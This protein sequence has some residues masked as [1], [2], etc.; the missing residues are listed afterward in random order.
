MTRLVLR[1]LAL[2]LLPAAPLLATVTSTPAGT[3]ADGKKI[4]WYTLT[5]KQGLRVRIL[6]FGPTL[7]SVETP[8][9]DGHLGDI[10]LGQN[11]LEGWL[12]NRPHF[13]TM[14]GR[15]AN[16]LAYGKMV[17]DGR[18]YT[19]PTNSVAAGIPATIH[20]GAVGFDKQVWKSRAIKET[21]SVEMTLVSPNGDQGF[22]GTLSVSVTFIL[23]DSDELRIVCLATADHDTVVNLSNHTYWN[24]SCDGAKDVLGDSVQIEADKYL[25]MNAGHI[26]NGKIEPVEGTPFDFTTPKVIGEQLK[27]PD[28]QLAMAGGYDHCMVLRKSTSVRLAARVSDPASG[29]VLELYSDQPGVQFYTA[30][31]V[32]KGFVGK[33]G[34]AYVPHAAFCLEPEKFPNSPNEPSFP[35][36]ELRLGETY[37]QTMV[38]RFSVAK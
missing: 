22:P 30:N 13:G 26:P 19:I 28:E 6:D 1:L 3:T 14:L 38:W 37:R 34:V 35:S 31:S 5:N 36:A 2:T 12:A 18:T 32:A 10:T 15:F 27:Q 21:N 7:T 23:N 16:R 29:R 33:G 11:S 24:L 20:G 8:D 4:T 25:P 17:I 9:R